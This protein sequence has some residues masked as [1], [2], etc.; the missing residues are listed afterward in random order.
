MDYINNFENFFICLKRESKEKVIIC[1]ETTTFSCLPENAIFQKYV[2]AIILYLVSDIK[3]KFV[4][5]N[6]ALY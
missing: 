2:L 5:R 6:Y 3:A 4:Q 1:K